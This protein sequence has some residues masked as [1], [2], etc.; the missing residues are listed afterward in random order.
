MVV[1]ADIDLDEGDR[2]RRW[3]RRQQKKYIPAIRMGRAAL[4]PIEIPRMACLDRPDVIP[5]PLGSFVSF[6]LLLLLSLLLSLL[7]L[8]PVPPG[9]LL[10]E[11]PL[12]PGVAEFHVSI[13]NYVEEL[14]DTMPGVHT[15]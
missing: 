13:L 8:S 1:V 4:P 6:P 11:P 10:P 7:L 14:T 3:C 2:R 9:L 5:L 15:H 12:K